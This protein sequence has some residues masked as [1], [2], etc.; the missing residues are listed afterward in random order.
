ML[1]SI[2]NL[3]G[4]SVLNREQQKRVLGG[5]PPGTCAWEGDGH[6][7]GIS[8][9]SREY[10]EGASQTLGGH[11]CCDSCCSVSWL[12]NEHK[13]YLGCFQTPQLQG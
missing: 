6:Y 10:A 13:E 4:I 12:D 11:W 5:V 8:G 1:Q 2:L 3:D 7:S 9:T